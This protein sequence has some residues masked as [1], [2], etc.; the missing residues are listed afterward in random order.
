MGLYE[1]G[2]QDLRIHLVCSDFSVGRI[3]IIIVAWTCSVLQLER[4]G[5]DGPAHFHLV[6]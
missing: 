1:S 3:K 2:T 6:L 5:S 4:A